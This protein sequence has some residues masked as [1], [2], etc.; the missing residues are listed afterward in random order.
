MMSQPNNQTLML[1]SGDYLTSLRIITSFRELLNFKYEYDQLDGG[2]SKLYIIPIVLILLLISV[3]KI[4]T[5][6]FHW[7]DEFIKFVRTSEMT[8]DN[9]G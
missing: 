3:L 6:I 9:R 1:K 5:H 2:G 8:L 7:L 4:G